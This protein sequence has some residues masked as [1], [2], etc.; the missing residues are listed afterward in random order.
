[1]TEYVLE[2]I[3]VDQD[4]R[5]GD[6]RLDVEDDPIDPDVAYVALD[7][8]ALEARPLYDVVSAAVELCTGSGINPGA[9]DISPAM[10]VM[11]LR[12]STSP[13][14]VDPRALADLLDA[15]IT[16]NVPGWWA[17]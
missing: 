6:I 8:A 7:F 16:A 10:M 1:M 15:L 5:P 4:H 12:A 17:T 9:L 3:D 11:S 13:R 14:L 2:V